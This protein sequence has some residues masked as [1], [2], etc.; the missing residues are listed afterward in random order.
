MDQRWV[1]GGGVA[2]LA[3]AAAGF[4]ALSA[5]DTWRGGDV[6]VLAERIPADVSGVVAAKGFVQALPA[7]VALRQQAGDPLGALRAAGQGSLG[8]D[9]TDPQTFSEWGFDPGRP[10]GVASWGRPSSASSRIAAWV[11]VR[12]GDATLREV[13]ALLER[14]GA[15][16][17]QTEVFGEVAWRSG[18]SAWTLD[19]DWLVVVRAG[20]GESP[21]GALETILRPEAVLADDAEWGAVNRLLPDPWHGLLFLEPTLLESM[22]GRDERVAALD[23]FGAEGA[24]ASVTLGVERST[25]RLAVANSPEATW[26]DVYAPGGDELADVIAGEPLLVARAGVDLKQSLADARAQ[27]AEGWAKELVV[28]RDR[29]GVD[30]EELLGT[31]DGQLSGAILST[32][33]KPDA[34]AYAGVRDP[35]AAAGAL[36]AIAEQVGRGAGLK[37]ETTPDGQRWWYAKPGGLGLA[38]DH[39]VFAGAPGHRERVRDALAAGGPGYASSLP[40]DIAAALRAG[41]PLVVWWDVESTLAL[42]EASPAFSQW[43]PAQQRASLAG[44]SALGAELDT[45]DGDVVVTVHLWPKW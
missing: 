19:D 2:V 11:P 8:V 27:D 43:L 16:V 28:W 30:A 21:P 26:T 42:L 33:G 17:S 9:L 6:Q 34:L 12:D 15:I 39:V 37:E 25:L 29:F 35:E 40:D 44:L 14:R 13:A 38:R 32:D 7:L 22:A 18:G 23:S 41:P 10:L 5:L 45:P 3:I 4:V 20:Q 24:G 1:V 36:A 31:L